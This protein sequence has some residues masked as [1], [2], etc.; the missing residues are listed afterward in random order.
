MFSQPHVLFLCVPL[1]RF[2]HPPI[3]TP[4]L[5]VEGLPCP[6]WP[7][8]CRVSQSI[9][10]R[11]SLLRARAGAG[12]GLVWPA[13]RPGV[14]VDWGGGGGGTA[15][16]VSCRLERYTIYTHRMG[17]STYHTTLAMTA[18]TG[19]VCVKSVQVRVRVCGCVGRRQKEAWAF[20][21]DG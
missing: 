17:F 9:W 2:F 13:T 4:H 7:H 19:E 10:V 14:W 5:R 21:F 1:L 12:Q 16:H 8:V 20:F 11:A 18:W 15:A 3:P 6:S